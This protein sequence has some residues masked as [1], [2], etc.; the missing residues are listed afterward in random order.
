[1]LGVLSWIVCGLIVGLLARAI[2]PGRQG[3]GF[4]GTV[5]LGVI[6]AFVGGV[7]ASAMWGPP[8]SDPA[9]ADPATMWPG[10]VMALVGAVVVLWG[11][12]ALAGR[13]VAPAARV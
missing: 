13:P 2:V 8:P 12:V 10:W 6:G 3:I 4:I 5:A 1:M 11:Y 9:L 7:M